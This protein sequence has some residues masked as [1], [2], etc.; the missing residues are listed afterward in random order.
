MAWWMRTTRRDPRDRRD[1]QKGRPFSPPYLS[2]RRQRQGAWQVDRQALRSDHAL[3]TRSARPIAIIAGRAKAASGSPVT[4]SSRRPEW[5]LQARKLWKD[6]GKA[7]G[8]NTQ[9]PP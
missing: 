1:G 3:G 5:E 8:R 9:G 4:T 7:C 6:I 2:S